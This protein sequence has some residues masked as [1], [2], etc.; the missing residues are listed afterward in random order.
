L[1]RFEVEG[2][3]TAPRSK[4]E[5]QADANDPDRDLIPLADA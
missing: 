1:Y 4:A 5:P 3:K 2:Q